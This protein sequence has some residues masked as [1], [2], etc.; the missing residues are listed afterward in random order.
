M[1][2]NGILLSCQL[3]LKQMNMIV[4]TFLGL[5]AKVVEGKV[6]NSN[7][8]ADS[9]IQ[10]QKASGS[11]NNGSSTSSMAPSALPELFTGVAIHLYNMDPETMTKYKRY[12]IA[13][14]CCSVIRIFSLFM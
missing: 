10:V 9:S 7:S 5:V 14:P 13:Y 4:I 12:I 11:V 2:Q 3:C 1:T 6:K 8:E